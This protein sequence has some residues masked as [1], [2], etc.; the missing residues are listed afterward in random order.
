MVRH[1][2]LIGLGFKRQN[3]RN[4]ALKY[5]MDHKIMGSG[6]MTMRPAVMP[7]LIYDLK[8]DGDHYPFIE[9]HLNSIINKKYQI[10]LNS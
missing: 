1:H 7:L 6:S 4:R 9:H 2:V 8:L 10:D 5:M 3:F